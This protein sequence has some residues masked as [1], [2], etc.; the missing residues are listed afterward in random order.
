MTDELNT[1]NAANVIRLQEY[2]ERNPVGLLLVPATSVFQ[3]HFY[4]AIYQQV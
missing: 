1:I 4:E 3:Q 2:F